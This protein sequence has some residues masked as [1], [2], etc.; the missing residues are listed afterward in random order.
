MIDLD[1]LSVEE[2]VVL[3][4]AIAI[5]LCRE[6]TVNEINVIETVGCIMLTIAA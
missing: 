2:I 3:T 1:N 5:E 6:K 4:N